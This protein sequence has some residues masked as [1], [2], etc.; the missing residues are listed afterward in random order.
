[1]IDN[2]MLRIVNW[3]HHDIKPQNFFVGRG[4]FG[5]KIDHL[6]S[7]PYFDLRTPEQQIYRRETDSYVNISR[8]VGTISKASH[9]C[10]AGFYVVGFT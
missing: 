9:P 6:L 5:N 4:E 7:A 3:M 1:V 10:S 2:Q 8:T